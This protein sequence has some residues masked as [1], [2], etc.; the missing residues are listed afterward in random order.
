MS[1]PIVVLVVTFVILLV[2]NVP[3]AISIGISSLLTILVALDV[4]A[5]SIMAQKMATGVDSFSLLAIPFFILAG[6][7]MG[8][9]GIATRLINFA[10]SLVGR[11]TG[12]LGYVNILTCMLFGSISGSAV[13]A[14]SSVGGFMIPEMNKKG[15]DRD[16]NVAVT[17]TAAT[18][19]LMIPPSNIMI[20]Y[21]VAAP[22]GVSIAAL[23]MAGIMPGI[24]FGV[25]LMIVSGYIS[26]KRGY[27]AGD[28]ASFK[29]ILVAFGQAILSLLLIVIVLGGILLGVFTATEAAAVAVA[30]SFFL[31]VVLYKKV[32]LK[33][34]PEILLQCG[35]TTSIVMLLIATSM[36]MAWIM[37]MEQ[38]PQKVSAALLS[39]SDNKIV[40]F[41]IINMLLLIVGTFMDMTPAVLIFTPIFLPVVVKLGMH[42]VHFGLMLIANLCIGLCTPPVGTCLFVGCGVGKTT[43]TKVTKHLLPF[44]GAMVAALM[45]VTYWPVLTLGIPRLLELVPPPPAVIITES[46]GTTEVT[47]GGAGDDYTITLTTSPIGDVVVVIDVKVA[48]GQST[49]DGGVSTTVTLTAANWR[50]GVTV[51]VAAVVDAVAEG[52]HASTI[53]HA[54]NTAATT[55]EYDPLSIADVKVSVYD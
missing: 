21:A 6:L 37:T 52:D 49:V 54:V 28:K 44:F 55:S 2:M 41:L 27:G 5:F 20:V 9:G 32:K 53:T 31:A 38:V 15:Y 4:N 45:F 43:I 18:T 17:T 48:D 30:Y 23:F 29:Q 25:F 22:A 12:G 19:G 13:A 8:R 1:I 14:V 36:C 34:L 16:F 7:L 39:L 26:K 35:I 42:P 51:V 47:E 10:N 40:I 24:V 3:I 33:Q 46:S 50:T 11:F